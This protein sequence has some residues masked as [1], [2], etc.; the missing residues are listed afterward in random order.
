MDADGHRLPSDGNHPPSDGN[1][2]KVDVLIFPHSFLEGG[3]DNPS[4]FQIYNFSG[5]YTKR[6][7]ALDTPEITGL[8]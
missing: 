7:F 8:H 1:K 5:H 2:A 3:C 6:W 4:G